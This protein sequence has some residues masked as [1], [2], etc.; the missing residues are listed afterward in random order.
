MNSEDF[1]NK[2]IEVQLKVN[3][4]DVTF[5]VYAEY[6]NED[7]DSNILLSFIDIQQKVDL[8]KDNELKNKVL[9]QQSKLAAKGEMLSMISHQWKQ[10]LTCIAMVSNNIKMAIALH[11]LKDDELMKSCDTI[12]KTTQEMAKIINDFISLGKGEITFEEIKCKDLIDGI[13]TFSAGKILNNN[14][15][16]EVLY[17]TETIYTSNKDIVHVILNIINNSIQAYKTHKEKSRKI[18]ILFDKEQKYNVITISDYAGGVGI[19]PVEKI[20]EPYF[21]TKKELNGTGLGLY[22]SKL[23]V[24]EALG[25]KISVENSNGGLKTV[26]Q[27]PNQLLT[28][29]T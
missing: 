12:D 4:K 6:F 11:K 16:Y 24:E 23:I 5:N 3:G 22:M 9:L 10:P 1:T 2:S 8:L 28:N 13:N 20:F 27:L 7:K 25:G 17:K 29:D 26:I 14:I 21:S 19:K 18:A 15:E